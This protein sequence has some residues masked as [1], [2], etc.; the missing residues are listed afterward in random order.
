M[1]IRRSGADVSVYVA[2]RQGEILR[3]ETTLAQ[4]ENSVDQRLCAEN[5]R[6]GKAFGV[7]G[8]G[9]GGIDHDAQIVG[10]DDKCVA[11]Q[12]DVPDVGVVDDLATPEILVRL[13]NA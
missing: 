10:G 11:L 7:F 9:F 5:D 3:A 13:E 8:F 4:P 12:R 6:E 2:V 1:T